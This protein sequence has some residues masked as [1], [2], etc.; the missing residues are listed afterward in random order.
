MYYD[1]F[2]LTQACVKC[3]RKNCTR[4]QH[5]TCLY[6]GSSFT[7]RH[8]IDMITDFGVCVSCGVALTK[9]YMIEAKPG[10]EAVS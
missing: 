3:R 8:N 4:C 7:D 10:K 1:D 5:T 2:V 9:K 6:C